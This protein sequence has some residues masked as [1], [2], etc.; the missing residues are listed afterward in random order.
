MKARKDE[1]LLLH[2]A[3]GQVFTASELFIRSSDR[4]SK[5]PVKR[6]TWKK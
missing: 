3:P 5:H 2:E 1:L 4:L 6:I